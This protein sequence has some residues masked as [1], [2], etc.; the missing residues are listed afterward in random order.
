LAGIIKQ[1]CA[2][3]RYLFGV[4]NKLLYIAI[5]LA[6]IGVVVLGISIIVIRNY[7]AAMLRIVFGGALLQVSLTAFAIKFG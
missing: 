4:K 2:T 6:I 1:V 3:L 7:P 5:V